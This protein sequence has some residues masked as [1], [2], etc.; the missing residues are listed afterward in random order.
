MRSSTPNF[1]K[2][3][4]SDSG[5]PSGPPRPRQRARHPRMIRL[6]IA[7]VG[8]FFACWAVAALGSLGAADLA[9]ALAL[10][11]YPLYSIAAG[12]GWLSGNVYVLRSRAVPGKLRRRV[13]AVY[14]LGPPGIVYLLR[15][16]APMP[17]QE[18]APLVP[19]YSFGVFA[20]LFLVPLV[21]RPPRRGTPGV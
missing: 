15:A 4:T 19:I 9:G 8:L 10:P 14:F 11:L 2:R 5:D 6:E 17:E 21:L 7:L 3:G 12:L 1:S 16:M 18:A 13:L 20:V